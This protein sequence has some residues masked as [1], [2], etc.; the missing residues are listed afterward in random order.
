MERV[1]ILS[2]DET[3]K[4]WQPRATKLVIPRD[5]AS[6]QYLVNWLDQLIDEVG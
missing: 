4:L 3:Q 5:E 2:I 1:K 6:Y